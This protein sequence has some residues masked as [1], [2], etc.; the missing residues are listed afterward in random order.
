MSIEIDISG[1]Q[2]RKLPQLFFKHLIVFSTCKQ[3]LGISEKCL[4]K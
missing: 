2:A 3:L 4:F 1:Y